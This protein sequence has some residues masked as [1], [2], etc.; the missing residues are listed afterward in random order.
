LPEGVEASPPRVGPVHIS[1][2][3]YNEGMYL[4]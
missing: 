2:T 3:A 1:Q 4:P